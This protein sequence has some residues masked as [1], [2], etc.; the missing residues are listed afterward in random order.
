[1]GDQRD[2]IRQFLETHIRQ[3]EDQIALRNESPV[4][5]RKAMFFFEG[6]LGAFREVMDFMSEMDGID[7]GAGFLH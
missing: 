5:N 4:E 6:R 7:P 3:T 2:V 1:M